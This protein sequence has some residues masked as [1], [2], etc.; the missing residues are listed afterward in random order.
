MKRGHEKLRD[1]DAASKSISSID[2]RNPGA[3]VK[4]GS[5]NRDYFCDLIVAVGVVEFEIAISGQRD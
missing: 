4:R 2:R 5:M 1:R 3:R